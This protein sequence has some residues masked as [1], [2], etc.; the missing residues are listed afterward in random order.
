[1]KQSFLII[2]QPPLVA[3]TAPSLGRTTIIS[4]PHP[5]PSQSDFLHPVLA[6]VSIQHSN[7]QLS[8]NILL[9]FVYLFGCSGS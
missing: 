1:M 8:D 7:P 2:I 4:P 3:S 6:T 5:T 9:I